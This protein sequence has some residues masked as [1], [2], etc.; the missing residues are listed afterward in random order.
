MSHSRR[1]LSYASPVACAK[2]RARCRVGLLGRDQGVE[3]G[4]RGIAERL[5][6]QVV[7]DGEV[8]AD[9]SRAYV[10]LLADPPQSDALESLGQGDTGGRGDDFRTSL[11]RIL[12]I[13]FA[14]DAGRHDPHDRSAAY[15]STQAAPGPAC[16]G[17]SEP[18]LLQ[19]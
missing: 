13:S 4:T 11:G 9:Q 1:M 3:F 6:H 16:R 15:T 14:L 12:S 5:G 8:M 18:Y 7:H 19:D 17:R 10:A 2:K